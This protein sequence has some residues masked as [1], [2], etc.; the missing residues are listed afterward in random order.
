ML[1]ARQYLVYGLH[2]SGLHGGIWFKRVIFL[3]IFI[4]YVA[5]CI[6]MQVELL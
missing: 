6:D 2:V 1:F 5:F 3:F 4:C